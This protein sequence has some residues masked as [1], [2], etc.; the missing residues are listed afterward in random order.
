MAEEKKVFKQ[1]H[2]VIVENR[3]NITVSGVMDIDS[4]DEESVILFT[5]LGELTIKGVNLHIN[6]ID[7]N[8]GDL[9][10]E[11]EIESLSYSE[12]RP[13]KGTGLL[14]RLFR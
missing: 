12:D 8:A 11:G 5:E 10:M 13:Q 3:K 9:T 2:N 1:T 6:K 14:S 4:F 7:V